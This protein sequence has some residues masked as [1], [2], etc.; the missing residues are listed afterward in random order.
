MQRKKKG[1]EGGREER[2]EERKEEKSSLPGIPQLECMKQ[3]LDFGHFES[4]VKTLLT[5]L[6]GNM[7]KPNRSFCLE[8][9]TDGPDW[10]YFLLT[11]LWLII[12]Y[13]WS[14]YFL[15][16]FIYCKSNAFRKLD[17]W[18]TQDKCKDSKLNSD[19]LQLVSWH[20]SGF[21]S[22]LLDLGFLSL[23]GGSPVLWFWFPETWQR[24][25]GSMVMKAP[26][27]GQSSLE[28]S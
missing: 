10:E 13:L 18:N 5:D 14:N 17:K 2:K 25:W 21:H 26:S 15:F 16:F 11:Q 12:A 27:V 19:V 20:P 4:S 23:P 9:T 3:S 8:A 22:S 7:E 6:S 24:Q 1:K 28:V